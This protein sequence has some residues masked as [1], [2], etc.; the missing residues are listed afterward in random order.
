MT[1]SIKSQFTDNR[2]K[3]VTVFNAFGSSDAAIQ[4]VFSCKG[5][6][7]T[8]HSIHGNAMFLGYLTHDYF[9]ITVLDNADIRIVSDSFDVNIHIFSRL[10]KTFAYLYKK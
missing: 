3:C 9:E 2:C 1:K 8:A 4:T 10:C 7:I 5:L 6:N